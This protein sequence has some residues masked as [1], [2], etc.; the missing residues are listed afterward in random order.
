[1]RTQALISGLALE[2][3]SAQPGGVTNGVYGGAAATRRLGRYIT[4]FANYTAT[5]QSSSSALP[6]NAISG[7]SQ[8][9]GFGIGYSPREMHLR[10]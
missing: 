10:K 5:E 4:I 1:M 2:L 3:G 6:T 7:L 8:V 9:I